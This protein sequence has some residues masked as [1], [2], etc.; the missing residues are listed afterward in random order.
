VVFSKDSIIHIA[1]KA[2]FLAECHRGPVPGGSFCVSDW[3]GSSDPTERAAMEKV[4]E[5]TH[6]HFDLATAGEME[7]MLVQAGFKDVFC[8]DRNA[9]YADLCRE[10]LDALDPD[11]TLQ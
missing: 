8:R 3:L 6:L 11:I 2:A 10:E 1:D 5:G 7:T 4:T 9:W